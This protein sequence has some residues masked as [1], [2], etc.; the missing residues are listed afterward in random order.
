MLKIHIYLFM[1][2]WSCLM[3]LLMRY[4]ITED[5]DLEQ[6]TAILFERCYFFCI[7]EIYTNVQ[8]PALQHRDIH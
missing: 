5:I 2:F 1:F 6:D 3:Q 8:K 7:S 4:L